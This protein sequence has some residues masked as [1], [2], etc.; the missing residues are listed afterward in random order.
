MNQKF[1]F[2]VLLVII[3]ISGCLKEKCEI[4]S[5]QCDKQDTKSGG[6][7]EG[8][9][10]KQLRYNYTIRDYYLNSDECACNFKDETKYR[11]E[12]VECCN[13]TDCSFDEKCGDNKCERIK[14]G[15]CQ[16]I[17]EHKCIKNECCEDKD[18]R[19]DYECKNN[20]C[21]EKPITP[22]IEVV[23]NI[24]ILKNKKDVTYAY[25]DCE[26]VDKIAYSTPKI[27]KYI[28]SRFDDIFDYAIIVTN[29]DTCVALLQE[30]IKNEIKGI[31][32]DIFDKSKIYGGA[33]KLKGIV[34][35]G[36]TNGLALTSK[37]TFL[38]E[39][40]HNWGIFINSGLKDEHNHW[41]NLA[42]LD[43]CD[44]MSASGGQFIL[45]EDGSYFLKQCADEWG[46]SELML[47][48]M[49]LVSKEEI[50]NNDYHLLEGVDENDPFK[51]Y[52]IKS[53]YSINNIIRLNGERIP[54]P[55]ESKKNF[56]VAFILVTDKDG[57]SSKEIKKLH[58]IMENYINW[59]SEA[60]HNRANIDFSIG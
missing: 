33:D 54:T 43:S 13:D 51:G 42:F 6:A 57:A 11:Y 16:Y 1:N 52:N 40:G 29:F 24:I 7:L 35:M 14:C 26:A 20:V 53:T 25:D 60:T 17:G 12:L 8:C 41:D 59:F 48:L 56:K 22:I 19:T 2:A 9:S 45:K 38:H 3:L 47:Y 32:L 10:F 4:T 39:F 44:A 15:D 27:M 49:G 55:N 50:S 21:K 37:F 23:D 18:C 34:R 30:N 5:S 31:G 36:S 28:Y 58:Q 46:Y